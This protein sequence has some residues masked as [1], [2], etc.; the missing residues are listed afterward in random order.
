MKNY[1]TEQSGRSMIEMLGV[2]AI[3][4]VLS[5]AGIA[6]YS[7]AM[8]KFK[9]N[10]LVDQITSLSSSV[11]TMFSGVGTYENLTQANAFNLG[12][13]PEDATKVCAGSWSEGCIKHALNGDL[14]VHTGSDIRTFY[15]TVNGLT[16]DACSALVSSDWGGPTSVAKV[17]ASGV[18]MTSQ[19]EDGVSPSEGASSIISEAAK[20]TCTTTSCAVQITYY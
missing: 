6:G 10:K 15:I 19:S 16:K 20:C 8:A 14:D 18:E 12:L 4:G 5:V 11:R 3:V 9:T 7:K 2:L 17:A 1:S 13:V